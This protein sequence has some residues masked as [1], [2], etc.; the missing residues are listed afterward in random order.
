MTKSDFPYLTQIVDLL[1]ESHPEVLREDLEKR[2]VQAAAPVACEL[3]MAPPWEACDHID[4]FPSMG[5]RMGSG[6]N[7]LHTFATWFK[8]L[9]GQERST[10]RNRHP[11]PKLFSGMYAEISAKG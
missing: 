2:L 7:Y 4:R 3:P 5:W 1:Q 9:S 6:E 8:S 10:Y 11:E